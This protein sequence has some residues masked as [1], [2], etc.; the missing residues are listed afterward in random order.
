MIQAIKKI[1]A[2]SIT[3]VLLQPCKIWRVIGKVDEPEKSTGLSGV[4]PSM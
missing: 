1:V 4:V 3:L 2:N